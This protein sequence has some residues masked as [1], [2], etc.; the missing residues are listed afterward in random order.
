M[1]RECISDNSAEN[2]LIFLAWVTRLTY[3]VYSALGLH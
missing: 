2:A 3:C 1:R